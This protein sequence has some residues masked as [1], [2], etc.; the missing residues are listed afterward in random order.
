MPANQL[1]H[2]QIYKGSALDVDQ[3][4]MESTIATSLEAALTSK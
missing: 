2:T 1:T 4:Y 3:N